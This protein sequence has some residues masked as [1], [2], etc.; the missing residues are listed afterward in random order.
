V[1][2]Y[3]EAHRARFGVE[4]I[5]RV[6]A[7]APSTYYAMR[8]RAPSARA[9]ADAE[10]LG[11]IHQARQG[12]RAAYGARRTWAE[13]H[14]RGVRVGRDRVA[15]LMRAAAHPLEAG[16]SAPPP[17]SPPASGPGTWSSA[18]SPRRGPTGSGSPT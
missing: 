7:V 6:L 13:L 14:R 17:R 18:A 10:L 16:G 11:Q 4:P 5:C 12:Y 3:I 15:R 9:L 1:T 2:R 8:N